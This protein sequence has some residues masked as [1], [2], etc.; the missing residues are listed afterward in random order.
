MNDSDNAD[1]YVLLCIV[2]GQDDSVAVD[3]KAE[4]VGFLF[5]CL[6]AI[7]EE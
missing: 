5:E 4:I 3:V 6:C 2:L 7:R 1:D